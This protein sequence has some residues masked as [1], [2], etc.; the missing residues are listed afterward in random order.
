MSE[1]IETAQQY[2][3][4]LKRATALRAHCTALRSV[5]ALASANR[6]S[7]VIEQEDMR[8]LCA[9]DDILADIGYTLGALETCLAD[10]ETVQCYGAPDDPAADRARYRRRTL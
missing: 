10:W 7:G 9:L 1:R 2:H 4:A 3:H 6:Y 8:D 5:Q